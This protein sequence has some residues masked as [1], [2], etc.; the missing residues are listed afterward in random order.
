M[1]DDGTN[2]VAP[3]GPDRP[4]PPAS[5]LPWHLV[6]IAATVVGGPLSFALLAG[7]A[8]VLLSGI[9]L[10]SSTTLTSAVGSITTAWVALVT[11]G[12]ILA[13]QCS[14]AARSTVAAATSGAV[15]LA[16]GVLTKFWD[17]P[18]TWSLRLVPTDIA[19]LSTRDGA[20]LLFASGAAFLIG[21]A[22][23][24]IAVS[25]TIARQ[26][27]KLIERAEQ[28][29]IT[30]GHVTVPPR[31][32]LA[33]HISAPVLACLLAV[34]GVALSNRIAA[35]AVLAPAAPDP[36]VL[37]SA[38]LAVGLMA[39]TGALSSLGPAIAAPVWL[40]SFV[41]VQLQHS[42]PSLVSRLGEWAVATAAPWNEGLTRGAA[43]AMGIT[44]AIGAVLAGGALGVHFARRDGRATQRREGALL[45]HHPTQ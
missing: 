43:D 18:V 7:A 13:C 35:E 34:L 19:G 25:A 44:W 26:H 33:A 4:I 15:W 28:R 31:S 29:R 39:L 20:T 10:S 21:A 2:A 9:G 5:R 36:V 11:A 24:S 32:R 40:A 23:V 45:P 3:D 41:Q 12:L 30:S 14:L 27:G 17:D 8:P 42:G 16:C 22:L 6:G 38:G 37:V 1:S